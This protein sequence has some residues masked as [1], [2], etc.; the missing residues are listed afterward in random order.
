MSIPVSEET[1]LEALHK[2]PEEQ[3]GAVLAFLHDM[4]PSGI[5]APDE[6][7]TRWTIQELRAMPPDQR[8]AILE[9]QAALAEHDYV[10]DPELTAFEAFGQNDLYVDDAETPTR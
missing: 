9:R 4:E 1:I 5:S 6:K 2:V 8:D 10:N 3:W 7:T